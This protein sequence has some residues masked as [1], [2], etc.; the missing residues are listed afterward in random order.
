[1]PRMRPPG[2]SCTALACL[3]ALV[4]GCDA[5]APLPPPG[6]N[7]TVAVHVWDPQGGPPTV[8]V[9]DRIRQ[10][11][12]RFDRML[13]ERVRGR[14]VQSDLDCALNAPSGVWSA[15]KGLLTLD[16]PVRLAGTWQGSAVLGNAA[17]A[18]LSR[19]G[20]A[21]ILRQLELWHRGQ[22][23]TAAVAELRRDRTL[24]APQG[25]SSAPLPGE[26]AA[27]LAALPDPLVLPQ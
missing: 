6:A 12:L 4:A 20:E 17:A 5:P 19:D 11:G 7:G 10:E 3:L 22:R 14:V 8:L 27:V 16:G 25:M 21:L 18:S 24:I 13:L 15:Q 23:L 2:P 9:A 26:L 1:M